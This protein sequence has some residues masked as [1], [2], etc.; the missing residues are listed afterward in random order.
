MENIIFWFVTNIRR[1]E[2][3]RMRKILFLSLIIGIAVTA[4]M[5]QKKDQVVVGT[6][7]KVEA[8]D[9]R[10]HIKD[11]KGNIHIFKFAASAAVHGT[12]EAALWAGDAT[13]IGSNAAAI[14]SKAGE[15]YTLRSF[16]WFGSGTAQVKKGIIRW[17]EGPPHKVGV[18]NGDNAEEVFALDTSAI[19]TGSKVSDLAGNLITT[20][21]DQNRKGNA[22]IVDKNGTKTIV[23]IDLN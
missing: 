19:I 12:T 3:R 5:G 1:T 14:G 13:V 10:V 17:A 16:H 9:K 11:S 22:Y 8:A 20:E 6:I 21:L 7:E 23:Y 15:E 4:A 2:G 18:K